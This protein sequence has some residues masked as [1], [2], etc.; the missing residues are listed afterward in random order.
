MKSSFSWFAAFFGCLLS[1]AWTSA[2]ERVHS[3]KIDFRRQIQ[4]ILAEHCTHCHGVD[5]EARKGGL[6][7]DIDRLAYSGGDSGESAI[8]PGN[9]AASQI[10]K[11]I[12]SKDPN[13]IMPPPSLNK[14]IGEA[15]LDLLRKWIEQ[16]AIYESHWAYT[17]PVQ[18]PKPDG[19]PNPIDAFV[20]KQ[21]S[22]HGIEPAPLAPNP[23][24]ARRM[25]LDTIGIP[26]TPQQLADF[27]IKPIDESLDRLLQSERYGEKWARHWLDVARYSDS[28]G[29]E[30]DLA[31]QQWA[32]RDWVIDSLNQDKPYDRFIVEQIAGDLLPN[33]TQDQI[34]ATG[35]LRNSMLN[36]EGAIIPEQFRMVEMFDRMDCIGKAT[37]GLTTQCAQCHNHKFDP[38]T[39]EEYYGMFAYLNNCYEAQSGVY[40]HEQLESIRTIHDAI[41][42]L[43]NKTK[44]SVPDWGAEIETW[45][46]AIRDSQPN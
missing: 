46:K 45:S 3:A 34:V 12:T 9:P 1:V 2:Q 35:F 24:L 21:L 43:E 27:A 26:P 15:Q 25:Y 42:E 30:K 23:T 39:Q 7:L 28:N 10:L 13:E 41:R 17:N 4:P 32:W 36:E 29:Y 22:S 20:R 19:P 38:I 14:P 8:V 37:L 40:S 44:Q 31:R 33:A 6:R 16:G 11:R 18:R 5:S